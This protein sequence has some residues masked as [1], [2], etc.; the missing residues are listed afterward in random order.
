V[1]KRIIDLCEPINIGNVCVSV[2]THICIPTTLYCQ[3]LETGVSTLLFQVKI[4]I[5]LLMAGVDL[6]TQP[7]ADR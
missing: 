3:F 7:S 6:L 2:H 5:H 4:H 1:H